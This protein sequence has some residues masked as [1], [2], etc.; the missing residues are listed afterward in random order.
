[1]LYVANCGHPAELLPI[2][3]NDSVPDIVD[4]GGLPIE[5]STITFTCPS[6][7]KLMGGP[8]S[9]TCRETGEWK[10]DFTGLICNTSGKVTDTQEPNY[11][12]VSHV[13]AIICYQ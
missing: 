2:I 12:A 11:N 5:G 9:A 3:N 1:M 8:S 13:L 4:N 10:P 6:G 7:L